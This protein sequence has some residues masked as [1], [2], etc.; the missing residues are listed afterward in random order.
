MFGEIDLLGAFMPT[1]VAWFVI[2]VVVFVVADSVLAKFGFYRLF[3]HP[4]LTRFA[5]FVCLFCG[6]RLIAGI[7]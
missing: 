7:L 4:P 5:L 3:W 2:A 6:G 1:V